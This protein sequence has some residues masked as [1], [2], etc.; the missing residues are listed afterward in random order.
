M[1]IKEAKYHSEFSR[2]IN[3]LVTTNDSKEFWVPLDSANTDYQAVMAWVDAG[4]TIE[5]AD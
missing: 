3:I 4:N 1:D 5:S 2:N